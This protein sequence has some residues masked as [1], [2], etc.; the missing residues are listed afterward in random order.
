MKSQWSALF[1][2]L[3]LVAF[4]LSLPQ[5][6][7][8]QS[9]NPIG[10]TQTPEATATKLPEWDVV[11]VRQAEP[12]N[13]LEGSGMM[14][15][16]D[17]VHAFCLSLNALIQ[18]AYGISE[19][20]RIVGAPD[21]TK[22]GGGW[23]I[24]AKVAGEDAAAFSKLSPIDRNRMV[25]MLLADRFHLKAHIEKREMPVYDLVI[26]KGGSKLKEATEEEANKAMLRGAVPG[27]IECI[28]MPL[29]TLPY[30]LNRELGRPTVNKT[31]LTG[32]YDFTLE[33]VPA[34]KAAIDETG[35]PSIFTAVEEQLGLKL[36]PAKEPMDVL[37]IDS[38]EP[39]AS[40]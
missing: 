1:A 6:T 20:S 30:F 22:S 8:G 28:S 29:S 23:N 3:V 11:S 37:V 25:Q 19:P 27:K 33:Y 4:C 16:K 12:G 9:P 17:G 32:K 36:E 40:N 7:P 15:R 26:A 39:P 5:S 10:P 24:D 14:V 21:W 31:G 34:S 35:G 38:I 13:C 2:W 18:I